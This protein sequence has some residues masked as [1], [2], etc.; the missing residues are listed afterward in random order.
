MKK[1]TPNLLRF[2]PVTLCL[3]FSL[4]ANNAKAANVYVDV[5]GT[6]AGYGVVTGSTYSWDDPNWAAA[7]GGGTATANWVAGNFARFTGPASYTVTVNNNES[8]AGLYVSVTGYTLPLNAAG[9]GAFSVVPN[10]TTGPDPLAQGFYCD[11][12]VI[13]NVPIGGTGGIQP[14]YVGVGAALSLNAINT[15]SGG[16]LFPSRSPFVNFNNNSAFGPGTIYIDMASG[17]FVPVLGHGGATL[18]LANNFTN[19]ISGG[20]IN[21]AADA[22]TPVISSG[23][24]G[25][26]ANNLNLRN[27]GNSTAPLTLTGVI[28]GTASLTMSANYGGEITLGGAS[29]YSGR[30]IISAGANVAGV[31]MTLSVGS[32]NSVSGGSASSNLGAPTSGNGTIGIGLTTFTSTLIYT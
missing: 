18:T 10:A 11:G 21:F 12:A 15:Y 5:N 1:L 3:L 6:T 32:I 7:T 23:N 31:G 19:C 25:L 29:T 26:A 9:S 22:S 14:Q 20:G 30:T 24:W 2:I 17:S 8:M 4:L 13:V 28:S 16:T 27:N